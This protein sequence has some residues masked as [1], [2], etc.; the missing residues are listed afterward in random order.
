M[1]TSGY[2]VRHLSK[3]GSAD[4]N[5]IVGSDP[6][7]SHVKEGMLHVQPTAAN[8]S[9]MV[10]ASLEE[11]AYLAKARWPHCLNP[12][13][14]GAARRGDSELPGTHV[15]YAGLDGTTDGPAT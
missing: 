13:C 10:C 7:A 15:C 3:L 9:R 12:D 1:D 2:T 6:Q 5:H 8:V 4:I 11:I 14:S